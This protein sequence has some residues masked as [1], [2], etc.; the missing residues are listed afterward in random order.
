MKKYIHSIHGL[1]HLSGSPSPFLPPLM[2][3]TRVPAWR[4]HG[5]SQPALQNCARTECFAFVGEFHYHMSMT[6]YENCQNCNT[7][8]D[9]E[10]R[11]Q[12]TTCPDC[13]AIFCR[14][15]L[16]KECPVCKKFANKIYDSGKYRIP[17]R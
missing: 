7:T 1:F 12:W 15:C 8:V 9:L 17:K 16:S 2:D 4:S 3:N 14:D 13:S 5:G 6:G 10:R 11:E